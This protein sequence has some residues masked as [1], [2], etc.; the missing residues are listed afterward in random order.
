MES[1]TTY[2]IVQKLADAGIEVRTNNHYEISH[3][4]YM[5]ADNATVQTG[6]YNYTASTSTTNAEN[7][8][9]YYNQPKFATFYLHD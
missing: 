1:S 2:S 3:D 7:Y 5:I 6:N 8:Q 9:I 4:K